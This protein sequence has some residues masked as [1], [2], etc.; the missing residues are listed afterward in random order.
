ME[1]GNYKE[2]YTSE[3]RLGISERSNMERGFGYLL[4]KKN[5]GKEKKRK[6]TEAE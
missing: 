1:N 6:T 2:Y 5:K 3:K 4:N